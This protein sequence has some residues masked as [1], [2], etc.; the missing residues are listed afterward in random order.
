MLPNKV[1]ALKPESVSEWTSK[2]RKAL[3]VTTKATTSPLVK[4]LALEFPDHKFATIVSSPPALELLQ[5]QNS[6]ALLVFNQ[7]ERVNDTRP[8]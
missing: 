3:F 6:P 2:G 7:G 5:I 4:A 8:S 1:K